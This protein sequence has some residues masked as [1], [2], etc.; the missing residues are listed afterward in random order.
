MS[1]SY[2]TKI[3]GKNRI[4]GNIYLREVLTLLLST[5]YESVRGSYDRNLTL[6]TRS[7]T[8]YTQKNLKTKLLLVFVFYNFLLQAKDNNGGEPEVQ[9]DDEC[10]KVFAMGTPVQTIFDFRDGNELP[11][12]PKYDEKDFQC[13]SIR[14]F[15]VI[16]LNLPQCRLGRAYIHTEIICNRFSVLFFPPP[17]KGLIFSRLPIL[18][19]R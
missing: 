6:S 4:F 8:Y 3:V 10:A 2:D 1:Q 12:K 13:K 17:M 11:L 15:L 7:V 16:M 14:E 18:I 19:L 9:L 5:N